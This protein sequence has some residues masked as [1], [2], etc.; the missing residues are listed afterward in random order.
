MFESTKIPDDWKEYL[1]AADKVLVPSKWCQE[2]FKKAGVDAEVVPLGYDDRFFKYKERKVKRDSGDDF[3]FL[4]YNAYNLRKGFVELVKAFVEEF[5]KDEPVK[6]VFKTTLHQPPFPFDERK[7]P[8]IKVIKGEVEPYQLAELCHQADCFVFPSRGE[9]FGITPLEA[10]AT[11]LP[12]IVPNAHGIGHYFNERYM[13]EVEV[14]KEV[15]AAYYRYKGQDVGHMYL[16]S[17]KH[18]RQQ[19][20]HVYEHQKEAREKGRLAAKYAKQ[21]TYKETAKRLKKIFSGIMS[22]PLSKRKQ[23]NLL[24]LELV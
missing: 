17:V 22:K 2:V 4:H 7:Y 21:Y 14:E 10:M 9:G 6:M 3:I 18:L 11:G 16:N 24:T 5:E 12:V 13:Y 15:P 1:D 8:N 19:M 23:S 20:R